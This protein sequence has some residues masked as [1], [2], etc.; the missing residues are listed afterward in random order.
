MRGKLV[1]AGRY[2]RAAT[3]GGP[4]VA[5][6]RTRK[7]ASGRRGSDARLSRGRRPRPAETTGPRTPGPLQIF[8]ILLPWVR[9]VLPSIRVPNSISLK[10]Q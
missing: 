5:A 4:R 3:G 2:L 10:W 7:K 6:G 9:R 1:A 8:P